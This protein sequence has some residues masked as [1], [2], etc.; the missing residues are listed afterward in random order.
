[1]IYSSLAGARQLALPYGLN[2]ARKIMSKVADEQIC[3]KEA[4]LIQRAE[5][6]K[7]LAGVGLD[8]IP[9]CLSE[10][11]RL[12]Q[13]NF[14]SERE[15]YFFSIALWHNQFILLKER[16]LVKF[17][18][19][20]SCFDLKEKKLGGLD[21]RSQIAAFLLYGNGESRWLLPD[22]WQIS[23]RE[24]E[25]QIRVDWQFVKLISDGLKR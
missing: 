1:M 8:L 7:E 18:G 21:D 23:M 2:P 14:F 17:I 10:T 9:Q 25:N 4:A 6:K 16:Y 20:N 12:H 3:E 5:I 22:Y 15:G 13:M 11:Y 19:S 24:N